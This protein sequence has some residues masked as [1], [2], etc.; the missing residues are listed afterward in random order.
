MCNC[1][2]K[3]NNIRRKL[4][5]KWINRIDGL[6]KKCAGEEIKCTQN[7][8]TAKVIEVS[9]MVILLGQ[10]RISDISDIEGSLKAHQ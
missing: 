7:S 2:I 1:N 9:G 3:G 5:V 4:L 6:W 10:N 8:K